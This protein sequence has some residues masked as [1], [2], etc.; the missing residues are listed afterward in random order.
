MHALPLL[1]TIE[2]NYRQVEHL[3]TQIERAQPEQPRLARLRRLMP[4]QEKHLADIA[5]RLEL[6]A[7]EAED[8]L[9]SA[10]IPGRRIPAA[11]IIVWKRHHRRFIQQMIVAEV[12]NAKPRNAHAGDQV[13]EGEVFLY[14]QQWAVTSVRSVDGHFEPWVVEP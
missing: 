2:T 1:T 6:L 3:L 11:E 5:S 10:Q 13:W 8:V 14:S 9:R 4:V 12:E 7:M